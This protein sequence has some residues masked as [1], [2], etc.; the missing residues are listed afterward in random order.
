MSH[1]WTI[2]HHD[3]PNHLELWLMVPQLSMAAAERVDAPR[4]CDPHQ[5]C[6]FSSNAMALITSDSGQMQIW[7]PHEADLAGRV[8]LDLCASLREDLQGPGE[9]LFGS[10]RSDTRRLS[11]CPTTHRLY[12]DRRRSENMF[13]TTLAPLRFGQVNDFCGVSDAELKFGLEAAGAGCYMKLSSGCPRRVSA[14]T[15]YEANMDCRP[16]R[17][18]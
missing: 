16:A 18:P 1:M 7:Q 17:W 13:L 4:R 12:L 15:V 8:L 6:G 14:T 3:G 11:P 10:Q 5:M 2:A 9:H